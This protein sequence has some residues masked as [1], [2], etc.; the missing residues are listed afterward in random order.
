M[1][2]LIT[3]MRAGG[4]G[5]EEEEGLGLGRRGE[6]RAGRRRIRI[7][8]LTRARRKKRA[9]ER[10][11][12]RATLPR[13]LLLALALDEEG[14]RR[15]SPTRL[16]SMLIPSLRSNP[17]GSVRSNRRV[18]E[19][20]MTKMRT[21][22]PLPLLRA[23][24]PVAALVPLPPPILITMLATA[25]MQSANPRR[26]RRKILL[27]VG[28]GKRRSK[29]PPP[30]IL[31]PLPL[32]QTCRTVMRRWTSSP[33][34]PSL[35]LVRPLRS[36]R[37]RMR[38]WRMVRS[39]LELDLGPVRERVVRVVLGRWTS[40]WILRSLDP[41]ARVLVSGSW[42]CAFNLFCLLYF[43]A[44]VPRRNVADFERCIVCSLDVGIDVSFSL[45]S[46][47]MLEYYWYSEA[48]YFADWLAGCGLVRLLR[49]CAYALETS[50]VLQYPRQLQLHNLRTELS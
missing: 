21:H 17:S 4:K 8:T 6:D 38:I 9:H 22:H 49:G 15:P 31:S 42:T 33:L 13:L 29:T 46:Q 23:L 32:L 28:R 41:R 26:R 30:P 48:V 1:P 20:T 7:R 11:R 12:K 37:R 50:S 2:T 47:C 39:R 10:R 45:L 18:L 25:M 36:A 14:R 43:P 44:L 19:R 24:L 35:S 3:L 34:L 27:R 40:Y 5:T 16:M